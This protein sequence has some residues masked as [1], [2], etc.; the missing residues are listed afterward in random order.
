MESELADTMMWLASL[1]FKGGLL[2]KGDLYQN[3]LS[4][5]PFCTFLW[6]QSWHT[7][8]SHL[9]IS[10]NDT[11]VFNQT[12]IIK[13]LWLFIEKE[14]IR[15]L[16]VWNAPLYRNISGCFHRSF[17]WGLFQDM[18]HVYVLFILLKMKASFF[19]YIY[20]FFQ[21]VVYSLLPAANWERCV[22]RCVWWRI[23]SCHLCTI[24]PSST[25]WWSR[26]SPRQR[27]AST[28]SNHSLNQ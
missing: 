7:V 2:A 9:Q 4:F 24:S 13:F 21:S 26:S 11:T 25:F 28:S 18:F 5:F 17:F 23:A 1:C 22:W 15:E 3:S 8:Q 6:T 27:S 12:L 20:I 16:F 19:I 10:A 14:R